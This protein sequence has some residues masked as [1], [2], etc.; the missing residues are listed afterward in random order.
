[1]ERLGI[2]PSCCSPC[3]RDGHPMQ[4]HA[5]QVCPICNASYH[6]RPAELKRGNA[7]YCSLGCAGRA[8]TLATAPKS[9]NCQCQTCGSNFYRSDSKRKNRHGYQFCSRTCKDKA[10]RLD[11]LAKLHPPHYGTGNG[12]YSYRKILMNARPLIGCERCGYA[13]V[14]QIIHVH[15]R[16]RDKS[17]ND[18][19]NLEW[20]CPNCHEAEHFKAGD[21]KWGSGD[22]I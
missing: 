21:G 16:D 12:E 14:L 1:M 11:G 5:P 8:K 4:P 22:R 19:D 7:K 10:Q 9:P 17:N 15:H 20:L 13:Q 6:A 2:E 18:P 3:K